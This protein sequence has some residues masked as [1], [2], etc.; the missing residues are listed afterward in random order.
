MK[1]ALFGT[2]ADP[3]TTGHLEILRW[4]SGRFDHVAVWAAD[5]PFKSQQTELQRR[6]T[7]LKILVDELACPNV[8][9]HPELSHPHTIVTVDRVQQRYPGAELTLVVGFDVARQLAKWYRVQELLQRVRVLVIPRSRYPFETEDL[10]RLVALGARASIAPATVPDVSST[11]Y[12]EGCDLS[13]VT[14]SIQAYIDREQLYQCHAH[15]EKQPV[16]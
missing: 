9:V 8:E 10:E 15:T 7:M 13:G 2:S 4:L 3:P 1:I 5:N 12:R 14:T 6:T 11:A 16:H